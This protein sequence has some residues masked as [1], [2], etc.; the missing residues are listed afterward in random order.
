M[1]PILRCFSL[2]VAFCEAH[3]F[4]F[5]PFGF[6][7]CLLRFAV[8]AL[9]CIRRASVVIFPVFFFFLSCV[10]VFVCLCLLL[11]C[12]YFHQLPSITFI[13][14]VLR[15]P[16]LYYHSI[17]PNKN[18]KKRSCQ[19]ELSFFLCF[20]FCLLFVVFNT[21]AFQRCTVTIQCRHACKVTV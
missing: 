14:I 15:F 3:V 12:F 5:P 17:M 1:Q 18:R 16:I 6:T 7:T 2:I 8:H 9:C 11:L 19:S 13:S 4:F 21:Y 20:F 10:C